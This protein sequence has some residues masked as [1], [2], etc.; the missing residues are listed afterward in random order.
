MPQTPRKLG[1][2]LA[3]HL[4]SRQPNVTPG[5]PVSLMTAQVAERAPDLIC[6][7]CM[8]KG[9]GGSE[10]RGY[11]TCKRCRGLTVVCPACHGMDYVRTP[12]ADGN[13]ITYCVTCQPEGE[14]HFNMDAVRAA[15]ARTLKARGAV[16]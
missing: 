7:T 10:L 1:D 15:I 13:T 16:K 12:T 9:R 5:S 3:Q 2:A 8:G 14:H 4:P 6:D 11:Y